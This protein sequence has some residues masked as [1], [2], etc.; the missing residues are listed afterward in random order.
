MVDSASVGVCIPWIPVPLH[1]SLL[2]GPSDRWWNA[3]LRPSARRL[4]PLL[5][6][7]SLL[8]PS[9]APPRPPLIA[10][11]AHNRAALDVETA[12][13]SPRGPWPRA[14]RRRQGPTGPVQARTATNRKEIELTREN[15][16]GGPVRRDPADLVTGPDT[17][18]TLPRR[19]LATRRPIKPE[20]LSRAVLLFPG[21]SPTCV[22]GTR[23]PH[24]WSDS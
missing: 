19:V 24:S 13:S 23:S 1:P 4:P 14:V 9:R 17:R 12:V 22:A 15:L 10:H 6:L 7:P 18:K 2:R 11:V 3:L 21:T 5:R 16:C 20:A 8:F